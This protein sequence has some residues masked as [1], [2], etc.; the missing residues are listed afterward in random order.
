MTS[1]IYRYTFTQ[2]VPIEDI[3]AFWQSSRQKACMARPKFA[4]TLPIVSIPAS[5]FV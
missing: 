1:E 4:S 3:E 2:A 5:V